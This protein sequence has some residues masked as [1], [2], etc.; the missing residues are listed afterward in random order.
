MKIRTLIAAAA[1]LAA[2]APAFAQTPTP[3]ANP[4]RAL[5]VEK[6][7]AFKAYMIDRIDKMQFARVEGSCAA[8]VTIKSYDPATKKLTIGVTREEGCQSYILAVLPTIQVQAMDDATITS[9]IHARQPDAPTFSEDFPNGELSGFDFAKGT[10]YSVIT[11][12]IDQYNCEAAV[13]RANFVTPNPDIVGEPK[14][15]CE[16]SYIGKYSFTC[17]FT[18]NEDVSSYYFVAGPAGTMQAQY[19]QFAP[20][21]GFSNFGELVKSWGVETKGEYDYTYMNMDPNTQYEVFVQSLDKNGEFAPCQSFLVSTEALGGEG[22]AKVEITLGD[23]KLQDWNGEQKYSQFVTYT[24]NDQSAAY[25]FAVQLASDYDTDPAG[26]NN[27]VMSE[28]PMPNMANWW[29]YEPMTTDYQIDPGTEFVVIA[30]AKNI[31]GQW[32]EPTIVRS[33]GVAPSAAPMTKSGRVQPRIVPT[34]RAGIPT[35]TRLTLTAK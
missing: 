7:G 5:L 21:M 24:P 25:R 29:F 33:T 12:G 6:T 28:P 9:Y 31:N 4:N 17:E 20:M 8:P 34:K 26:Y 35:P 11:I 2:S 16:F 13:S 19:E 1:L 30:A 22:E 10:D 3:V 23:Y 18:P 32:G 14:V 27:S 15:E